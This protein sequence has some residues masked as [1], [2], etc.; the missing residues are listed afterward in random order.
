MIDAV[1]DRVEQETPWG[2]AIVRVQAAE[3][4]VAVFEDEFASMAEFY[5]AVF[6]DV[7]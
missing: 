6:A 2:D 4:S 1:F 3:D 7:P 5:L